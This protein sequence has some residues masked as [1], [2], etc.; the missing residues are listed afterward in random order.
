MA[1]M[2]RDPRQEFLMAE[3]LKKNPNASMAL[4]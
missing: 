3:E 2:T 4:K 1:F